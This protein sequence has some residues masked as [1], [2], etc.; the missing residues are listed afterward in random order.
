MCLCVPGAETAVVCVES[1]TVSHTDG[2]IL[3]K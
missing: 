2:V 1:V 3:F